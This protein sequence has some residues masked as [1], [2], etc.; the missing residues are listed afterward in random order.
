MSPTPSFSP[1]SPDDHPPESA[2]AARVCYLGLGANLGARAETIAAAVAALEAQVP[3]VDVWRS[4]LFETVAVADHPQPPYLNAVL[5]A[6]TTARPLAL[7]SA[8][9][10]IEA[11]LGRA[12]PVGVAQA[13]RNIDID[14]LLYGNAIIETPALW[15]PHPE[16]LNRPFV[17]I[18]LAEIATPGLVHPRTGEPLDVAAP[19]P[20][21]VW[22][23][24]G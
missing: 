10:A 22:P 24:P 1:P 11:S 13:A 9:L 20:D 15:V 16:L 8:C 2:S 14:I 17:R 19:A 12:R 4:R 7:L 5:R 18:P 21:A 3:L 6:R 23:W